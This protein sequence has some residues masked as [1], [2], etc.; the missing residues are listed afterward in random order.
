MADST[1]EVLCSTNTSASNPTTAASEQSLELKVTSSW[2]NDYIH[3]S[4][5]PSEGNGSRVPCDICCVVDVSGS[6][7]TTVTI[8]GANGVERSSITRLDIAKHAL[9]TIVHSL[10]QNDRLSIVTFESN[11]SIVF[12]LT[13]MDDDGRSNALIAIEKLRDLGGTNLWDGLKTGLQVLT[14]GQRTIGSNAAL[15]L[16]TDGCPSD[17]PPGGHLSTLTQ[18][19]RETNFTCSV[20]TFGFGYELKSDLLEGL[21]EIGNSGSYAFIPDGSFV[22][23]IFVNAISNLLTTA[24]TN[25]KL[26]IGSIQ[27]A[28]DLTSIYLCNYSTE[29]S[30]HKVEL[31]HFI[32]QSIEKVLVKSE[33]YRLK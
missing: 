29:I 25:L 21:A 9:K 3:I 27:P 18:Y 10:I 19:K 30:N 11:P 26:S 13:Q 33:I 23:T 12:P 24:A 28:I 8:Q 31:S 20:N 14:E 6:M 32:F 15:F 17:D 5:Q 4:I 22:G 16:L 1:S 7:S 2:L